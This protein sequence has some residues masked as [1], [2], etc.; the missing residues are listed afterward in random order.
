MLI[1]GDV[2]KTILWAE[3]VEDE[4]K[5]QYYVRSRITR[6][7]SKRYQK[8]GEVKSTYLDDL[9]PGIGFVQSNVRSSVIS[10]LYLHIWLVHPV[11]FL[12]RKLRGRVS[13]APVCMRHL[14]K[15][16]KNASWTIFLSRKIPLLSALSFKSAR[17]WKPA[18]INLGLWDS[19]IPH[20]WK[21]CRCEAQRELDCHSSGEGLTRSSC[22][23]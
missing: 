3:K 8:W 19:E 14:P 23:E 22:L 9:N 13:I 6:I 17:T 12:A 4:T 2:P 21:F 18:Y 5:N 11:S 1:H 20:Y 10:R 16:N 15:T 7:I